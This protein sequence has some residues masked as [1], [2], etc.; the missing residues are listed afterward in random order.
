M[1]VKKHIVLTVLAVF[2]LLVSCSVKEDRTPCP[3]WLDIYPEGAAEKAS[4][5]YLT[6]WLGDSEQYRACVN[7]ALDMDPFWE[8]AVSKGSVD[9]S[10]VCGFDL[11]STDGHLDFTGHDLVIR[12]GY[13][14]SPV[15]ASLSQGVDCT[16][17][18]AEDH[19]DL[20]KQHAWLHLSTNRSD[21]PDREVAVRIC[22]QVAGIDVRTLEPVSGTMQYSA[23]FD[24]EGSCLV[25]LP[26]QKDDSLRL[27]VYMDGD[28]FTTVSLG[29][30]ISDYG[31][32]W[33]A[34]DLDDIWLNIRL[35]ERMKLS[36][37]VND[38]QVKTYMFII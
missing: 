13:D 26:R 7:P 17:E 14:F 37:R 6:G 38:W 30:Y 12:R 5:L 34:A 27:E 2:P 33:T 15:W 35:A 1:N 11:Q 28:L 8:V 29:E 20:H 10:A 16:G 23:P 25:C 22:G 24:S 18:F 9:C 36:V 4:S 19:V 31:Y 3:C 21:F 32:D